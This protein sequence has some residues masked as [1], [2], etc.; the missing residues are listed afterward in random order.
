MAKMLYHGPSLVSSIPTVASILVRQSTSSSTGGRGL[1]SHTGHGNTLQ[2]IEAA[3]RGVQLAGGLAIDFPTISV[4]ESFSAPTS[5]FLRNLMSMDTEEMIRAQPV[6]ACIMIGGETVKRSIEGK[7]AM[8]TNIT[9]CDKTV[10]AQIMGGISANK[11]VLPLITGPMSTGSYQGKRIGACTDCRNNW[12]S[13]RAGTIDIEEIAD[14]NE[15]LAPTV[16][17]LAQVSSHD[18]N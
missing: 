7:P 8:L 10:P 2:L 3:K 16:R 5:M 6:D 12:A 15:E 9:G 13:F 18:S 14:I 1:N 17:S 11:P 4:A